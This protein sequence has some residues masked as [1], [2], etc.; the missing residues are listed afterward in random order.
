MPAVGRLKD[1]FPPGM[2]GGIQIIKKGEY[3]LKI[4]CELYGKHDRHHCAD[5][6]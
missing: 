5:C 6:R 1:I 3:D 2:A 4:I